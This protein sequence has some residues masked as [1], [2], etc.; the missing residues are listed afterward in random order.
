MSKDCCRQQSFYADMAK[1]FTEKV[2]IEDPDAQFK[3]LIE[4]VGELAEA[5]NTGEGYKEELAD[6]LV[7]AFVLGE[8]M[9]IDLDKEYREKMLYNL[10]K[11]S[12][13]SGGKVTD[14]GGKE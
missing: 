6:V 9:D 2:Q 8:V 7:T 4:E 11:S 10:G 1:D 5:L 12:E 14:D 3:V 13:K